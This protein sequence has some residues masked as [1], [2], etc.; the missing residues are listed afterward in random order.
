MSLRVPIIADHLG[1]IVGS[2]KNSGLTDP[3]AQP[4]YTSLIHLAKAGH[5]YIKVSGLYRVSNKAPGFEDL[6]VIVHDL[7]RQVPDQLLY[8]SDWPHTGEAKDRIS[9]PHDAPERFREIDDRLV[10]SNLRAW[11]G[12]STWQKMCID[13]PVRLFL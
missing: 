6:Q 3:L 8:A 4:G 11:V 7:A 2:S 12:E 9:R 1:G 13:N 5:V 10:I